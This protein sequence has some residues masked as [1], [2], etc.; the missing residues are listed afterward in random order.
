LN[1]LPV[2]GW[3][4]TTREPVEPPIAS[5]LDDGRKVRALAL[6]AD[7]TVLSASVPAAVLSIAAVEKTHTT[8][9]HKDIK[10]VAAEVSTRVGSLYDH[11]FTG[12]GSG[13]EGEL[14]ALAAP[15]A[16]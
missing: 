15:C 8:T 6:R 3:V 14:V 1:G 2:D 16:L 10:V 4:I 9:G 11:G 13:G 7:A 12:C 5:R